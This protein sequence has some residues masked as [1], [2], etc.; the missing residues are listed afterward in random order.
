MATFNRN[1]K[2]TWEKPQRTVTLAIVLTSR[3]KTSLLLA[4]FV[5]MNSGLMSG[6]FA[7]CEINVVYVV[8]IRGL[9]RHVF[10]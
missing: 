10:Y 9:G 4:K 2:Y 1:I 8:K 5:F 7:L 3:N 6:P